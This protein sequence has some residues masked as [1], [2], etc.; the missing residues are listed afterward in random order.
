MLI[1]IWY[2]VLFAV[3]FIIY[4]ILL[5]ICLTSRKL[6]PEFS[7]FRDTISEVQDTSMKTSKY[8]NP[9]FALIGIVLLPLP[10]F[11]LDYMPRAG[12]TNI[13]ILI[14]Y[15]N[16]LGLIILSIW[17]NFTNNMHYIGAGIAMGGTLL[18]MILLFLPILRSQYIS[19]VILI[20]S[21]FALI[22]CIPLVY[23]NVTNGPR[24]ELI[25]NPNIWEWLEFFTL[26]LFII[27]LYLN[28]VIAK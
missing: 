1:P 9:A 18:A 20:I 3:C 6:Y 24:S 23:S 4:F 2:A 13:A 27:A 15:C 5:V 16:P 12:L 21:I 26:Q 11:L 28:L 8:I 14:L 17:P 22:I 7:I 19:N 10:V 25:H